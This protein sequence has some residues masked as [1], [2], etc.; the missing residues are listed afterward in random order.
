VYPAVHYNWFNSQELAQPLAL[1]FI[2]W[3][4]QWPESILDQ[5]LLYPFCLPVLRLPCLHFAMQSLPVG[6][7][8]LA[9]PITMRMCV[10]GKG[11]SL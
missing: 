7:L 11:K 6:A 3:L 8:L 4:V 2:S 9:V 5:A 1:E 10:Q